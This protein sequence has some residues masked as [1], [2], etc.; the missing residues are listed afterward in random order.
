MVITSTRSR[1]SVR[2]ANLRSCRE[3]SQ[4]RGWRSASQHRQVRPPRRRSAATRRAPGACGLIA[5]AAS[6]PR[7]DVN[8]GSSRMRSRYRV[9]CST[10]SIPA[11]PLD[12]HGTQLSSASRHIRSTGPMSVGHSRRTSRRPSPHQ[13]GCSASS[14]CRWASTRPWPGRRRHR[15]S[16]CRATR[17]RAPRRCQSGRRSSLPPA[18]LRT[19]IWVGD[20]SITVGGVIQFSGLYPGVRVEK[21]RPVGFDHDQPESLREIVSRRPE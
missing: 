5:C 9:S 13:R 10:A 7:V 18:R 1:R 12:S 4:L 20:S 2:T 3:Q 21:H 15:A 19:I 14:S 6:T 17:P 11:P 8:A 16:P